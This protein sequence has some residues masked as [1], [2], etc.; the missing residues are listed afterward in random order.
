MRRS[1][2]IITI[3]EA[4]RHEVGTADLV[5]AAYRPAGI[6]RE[7]VTSITVDLHAANFGPP[8]VVSGGILASNVDSSSL[9]AEYIER[10][11]PSDLSTR[12]A[13]RAGASAARPICNL[14]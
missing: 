11:R 7:A 1:T 10:T 14:I 13:Y 12:A 2:D 5:E 6:G 8:R 4:R 3:D 9:I